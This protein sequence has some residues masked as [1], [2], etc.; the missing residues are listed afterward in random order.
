MVRCFIVSAVIAIACAAHAQTIGTPAAQQAEMM[1]LQAAMMKAQAAAVR[2]GDETLGCEAL[3]KEMVASMDDPAIKA[4][5]A[6][7]N[8]A[9][10]KQL[11]EA[12]K[13]QATGKSKAMTPGAAAALADA[14]SPESAFAVAAMPT[15]AQI[16][17]SQQVMMEQ[18]KQLVPLMPILMRSQRLMTLAMAKG[19]A[20]RP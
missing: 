1:K 14:L 18:M 2:P 11:A 5:A 12:E 7:A 4:Y 17:Q 10:A 6:K 9:A 20:M 8:A 16:A 3:Q 19:C 13:S 15:Q